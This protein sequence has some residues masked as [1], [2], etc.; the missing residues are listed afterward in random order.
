MIIRRITNYFSIIFR[1]V[2]N[3]RG[4]YMYKDTRN[5]WIKCRETIIG[6][7][8]EGSYFDPCVIK[9]NNVFRM[10]VSGRKDNSIFLL[11]SKDGI[12][13]KNEGVVLAHGD[14]ENWDMRV[15]RPCVIY[16]DN[17]Y[18]MW[19][20][21]QNRDYI[22]S[23]GYAESFDGKVFVRKSIPILKSECDYEGTSIM[24]PVVRYCASSC[25]YKMWYSCGNS[26]EPDVVCYAESSD[27]VEWIKKNNG[28][29]LLPG[30]FN[31]DTFK[32]SVGDVLFH[33]GI[34]YMLYI[35]Y[36]NIDTARV[37]VAKS[38]DGIEWKKSSLGPLIS[39]TKKGWDAHS[40]YKPT[41]I[42]DNDKWYIWYNGRRNRVESIGYCYRDDISCKYSLME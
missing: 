36:S 27:G 12:E 3:A 18:Q 41:I 24:N 26:Y 28:P 22:S 21:G 16:N 29:V 8:K 33:S 32:V 14:E 35:G 38:K 42:I 25:K 39:P 15:N 4:L 34:Y 17:K 2:L 20:T 13:W 37:C 31:W 19:F 9:V 5:G 30:T 6:G 7:P 23:I 1:R 40:C 11:T 10:Y